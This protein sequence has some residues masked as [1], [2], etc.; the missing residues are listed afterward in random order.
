[1]AIYLFSYD[2]HVGTVTDDIISFLND[3]CGEGNSQAVLESVYLFESNKSYFQ[4]TKDFHAKHKDSLSYIIT[5]F[6]D[7]YDSNNLKSE[8]KQ[9]LN[10]HCT[11]YMRLSREEIKSILPDN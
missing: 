3:Y 7:F 6:S 8:A 4:I 2:S 1:M 10:E 5:E 9:W 11:Q